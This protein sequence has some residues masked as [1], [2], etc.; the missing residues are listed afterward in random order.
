M[1]TRQTNLRL[2]RDRRRSSTK[3]STRRAKSHRP[4]PRE[5]LR[6][7]APERKGLL[8]VGLCTIAPAAKCGHFFEGT[9]G[10]RVWAKLERAGLLE[11][12][13]DANDDE[14]WAVAGHGITDVVKRA[15]KSQT[16]LRRDE[17]AAG[18]EVLRA[19]VRRWA[20]R[21][22]V[23]AFK[24]AAEAALGERGLAPGSCPSFEG[25]PTWLLTSPWAKPE[26]AAR[27]AAALAKL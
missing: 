6:D 20:P 2:Q 7:F 10:R 23:F 18:V 1:N 3:P 25:V 19:K 16:D 27:E 14:V 11:R 9:F 21:A 5:S 15:A 22:I 17:I 8:L 4:Q 13:A 26:D 24:N 12:T